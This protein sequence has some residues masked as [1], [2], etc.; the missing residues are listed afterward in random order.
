MGTITLKAPP[1]PY[2]LYARA[3]L[4]MTPLAGKRSRQ[5]PARTLQLQDIAIDTRKLADYC[6][7]TGFVVRDTLP[8]IYPNALA[9]PLHMSLLTA[10]DFPF[11]AIGLVH[12]ENTIRQLRPV[13]ASERLA[14]RVHAGTLEPH[15]KGR[16][17]S[18]ITEVLAGDELVSRA[19]SKYLRRGKPGD[20]ALPEAVREFDPA[21]LPRVAQWELAGDLGRRYAR[22]SGDRNPIHMHDL[23]AKAFGFPRA[24]AHGMWTK[25]ACLAALDNRLPD[26]FAVVVRFRRP[27]S[28]P[29]TV[30]FAAG[31][32][33]TG[34]NFAV[35]DTGESTLHLEGAV[36]S[37]S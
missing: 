22:V 27:I 5:I 34:I 12:V 23:T 15:A 26:A 8:P 18:V 35:R 1:S 21:T 28:L 4:G 14:L 37:Q 6:R 13:R 25:A 7:V 30:V 20:G 33:G 11:P 29:S 9:F 19:D 24:I 3:A 16:Q 2:S 31:E 10:R 36:T 32:A 17:F